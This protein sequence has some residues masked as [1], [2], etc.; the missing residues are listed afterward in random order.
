MLDWLKGKAALAL[1]AMIALAVFVAG[2]L[3]GL[4]APKDA[5][6]EAAKLDVEAKKAVVEE[7][8][9]DVAAAEAQAAKT[10]E[11]VEERLAALEDKAQ[12][13]AARDSVDVANEI[14]KGA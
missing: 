10:H 7:R 14:I 4:F 3:R 1:A 8:K 9:A 11:S 5:K 12:K 13:D 6:H 2:L